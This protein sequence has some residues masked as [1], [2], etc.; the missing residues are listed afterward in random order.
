MFSEMVESIA[1]GFGANSDEIILSRNTTD[2]M[3]SILHGLH[4]E[5]GDVILTTHHE[6][7]AANSPFH[8]LS[9][10][11]G[12]NVVYLDIPVYTKTNEIS[13]DDFV[14]VFCRSS[15]RIW[16]SSSSD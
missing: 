1:A 14:N 8:I 12:V 4:F 3:C 10:R 11:Y 2:G 7:V 13:A 15:R 5:E 16:F 6:H 9:E